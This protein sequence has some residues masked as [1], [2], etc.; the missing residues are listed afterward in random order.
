MY[1]SVVASLIVYDGREPQQPVSILYIIVENIFK[2]VG[3]SFQKI[4][5]LLTIV[6]SLVNR[7]I[8]YGMTVLKSV[9]FRVIIK[10]SGRDAGP[11]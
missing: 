1:A 6:G 8:K 10:D 3:N 7:G 4:P 11:I 5:L 2:I 9:S